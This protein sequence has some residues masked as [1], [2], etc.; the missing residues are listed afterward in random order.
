MRTLTLLATLLA[1]AATLADET[2]DAVRSPLTVVTEARTSFGTRLAISA[3]AF[4]VFQPAELRLIGFPLDANRSVTL[5]LQSF[6]VT[7]PSAT[8]V[9]GTDQG[10]IPMPYPEVMLFRGRV[11]DAPESWVFL[12]VTPDR[13][14][15][16]VHLSDAEEYF[17][18]PLPE[19]IDAGERDTHVIYERFSAGTAAPPSRFHCEA[20]R[21]SGVPATPP[22]SS[23][24]PASAS[25]DGFS[26]V[27]NTSPRGGQLHVAWLAV[28][29]DWEYRNL[30]PFSG[31][32][33]AAAYAI[34]L[35]GVVNVIYERDVQT[36]MYVNFL[37]VWTTP[38]DPYDAADT[39]EQLPEFE[40][41]L[42]SNLG[43]NVSRDVNH[44]FSGRDLGGGRAFLDVLCDAYGVSGNLNGTFP[45]PAQDLQPDN[46]DV[47]V[48]PHEIGHNFG[49]PH[50]HC[51]EPP[52][53]TC[54][55]TG[56]DCPHPRVCQQSELM[57]YCHLCPGGTANIRLSFDHPAVLAQMREDVSCI[58]PVISPCHVNAAWGGAENG[59]PQVPYDNVLKGFMGVLPGGTLRI[60]A[61]NYPETLRLD[62][63]VRL[64]NW[65]NNGIV[66]IGQQPS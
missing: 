21:R 9:M 16:I 31:V 53:D 20:V 64:E 51:Y 47:V 57:S 43:N 39:Q 44:L 19:R 13:V 41:F 29:C 28:D 56:W 17:L 45:R 6:Q 66:R 36:R 52:I 15:G 7:G 2:V 49:S 25:A 55:G 65:L 60:M 8:I 3:D 33:E 5:E 58:R 50:T 62:R 11:A 48:V 35:I 12:G 1:N 61:G 27:D 32:G 37:R 10:D 54:A 4:A 59:Q 24:Q 63:A 26:T 18:A 38:N 34:E 46:W 14:N 22:P 42:A 30:A 23:I 40:N